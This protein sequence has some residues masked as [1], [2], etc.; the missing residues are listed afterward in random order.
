MN[1]L[2][3]EKKSPI[4]RK[5]VEISK[6]FRFLLIFF[7][8]NLFTRLPFEQWY[9]RR[10]IV[11][12]FKFYERVKKNTSIQHIAFLCNTS[13]LK[14]IFSAMAAFW[15]FE[16]EKTLFLKKVDLCVSDISPFI[17]LR[18]FWRRVERRTTSLEARTNRRAEAVSLDSN[19]SKRV[20]KIERKKI[21]ILQPNVH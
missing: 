12:F 6:N 11:H 5:I 9:A 19:R 1:K 15:D 13:T 8:E 20:K 16:L 7:N 18:Y 4:S 10:R 14:S 17:F 3:I 2:K 21:Y